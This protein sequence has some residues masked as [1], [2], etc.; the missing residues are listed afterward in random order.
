ML[1]LNWWRSLWASGPSAEDLYRK[2]YEDTQ[3]ELFLG[4]HPAA[5]EAARDPAMDRTAYDDGVDDAI[6]AY[7]AGRAVEPRAKRA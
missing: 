6:S 3:R 7:R 2:G 4:A 1:S 5:I